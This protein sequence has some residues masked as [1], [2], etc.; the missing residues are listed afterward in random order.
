MQKKAINFQKFHFCV[1]SWFVDLLTQIANLIEQ[2]YYDAGFQAPFL[3]VEVGG[4]VQQFRVALANET[5][6]NQSSCS[7]GRL[8]VRGWM[9]FAH[10]LKNEG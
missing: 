9:T 3:M 8:S 1:V 6:V 4:R 5:L 2:F 10:I 7:L